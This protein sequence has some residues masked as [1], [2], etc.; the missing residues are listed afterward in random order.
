MKYAKLFVMMMVLLVLGMG[1]SMA[2]IATPGERSVEVPTIDT[3]IKQPQTPIVFGSEGTSNRIAFEGQEYEFPADTS[4]EEM[5]GFLSNLPAEEEVEEEPSEPLREEIIIKKDEGVRKDKDG[6]HISYKDTEKHLTGGRGHLLNKEEKK[7]Y[8]K[9]TIIPPE[10]VD[11]WFNADMLIADE[12][13]TNILEKKATHVPDEVYDILLN[14]S[15]NLG[16]K[17][18]LGFK[19]M[20]AAIEIEDWATA[21]VE[22]EDSKWFKQV[23]NRAVRLVGRME[24]LAPKGEVEKAEEDLVLS[25]GLTPTKGGL[26]EDENGTLFR[27]DA[28]GNKTEV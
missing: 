21:A 28:E 20:W 26:F 9:G 18:L 17:R 27:V 12:A 15:F 8:P 2:V 3:P 24:A 14:M 13:L 22:M 19:K 10:Q 7:M 23:K 16:E 4:D 6:N 25:A 1:H 11:K 5:I